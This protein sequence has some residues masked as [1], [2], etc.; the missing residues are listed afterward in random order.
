MDITQ[1]ALDRFHHRSGGLPG[2]LAA[3]FVER[4]GHDA[5]RELRA[6]R[7]AAL[8]EGDDLGAEG[9]RHVLLAA[10]GLLASMSSGR[11]S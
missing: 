1:N 9:W 6:R 4:C 5:I 2:L 7:D 10:E 11:W 8:K 3:E